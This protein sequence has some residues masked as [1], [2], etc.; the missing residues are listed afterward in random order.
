LHC[1]RT[2]DPKPQPDEKRQ[3]QGASAIRITL[4]PE[5]RGH[6]DPHITRPKRRLLFCDLRLLQKVFEQALIDRCRPFQLPQSDDILTI[7]PTL[8]SYFTHR[9]LSSVLASLCQRVLVPD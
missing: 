9:L 6:D 8:P 1:Q 2:A 5:L 3:H 7:E 4:P